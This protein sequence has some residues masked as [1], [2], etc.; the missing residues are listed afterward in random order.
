MIVC[1]CPAC[2]CRSCSLRFS[3][4]G[5]A[6]GS[7]TSGSGVGSST[8]GSGVGSSTSG[9][10]VGSSTSGSGVGS[11]T[12]GSGMGSSTSGSGVGSSTSGSGMGSSTSGSDGGSSTSGSA[13]SSSGGTTSSLSHSLG[14]RSELVP[15]GPAARLFFRRHRSR[16]YH[17]T[18]R[19]EVSRTVGF[20]MAEGHIVVHGLVNVWHVLYLME[21][22]PL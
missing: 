8:S 10:G 20:V 5:S 21:Y 12:S 3:S 2:V 14:S 7:S 18:E 9:S 22:F 4:S 6:G 17:H 11:S 16:T 1:F 13:G 19:Q 15:G